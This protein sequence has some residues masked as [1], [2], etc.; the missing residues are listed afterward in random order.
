M[1]QNEILQKALAL[2]GELTE[3]RRDFHRHPELSYAEARTAAK[4]ADYLAAL[5]L[6]VERAIAG[7][8][9]VVGTL[10]SGKP[11]P[12]LLIR[13]D[14]DALPIEEQTAVPFASQNPG[15]MHACGHD[16]HTACAMVTAKLL[17]AL[18]LPRGRVKI[19]L[20]PAE[21]TPPGGAKTLVEEGGILDGV[22]AALA[23]HVYPQLPVG[24][25]GFLPGQMLANT[26]RFEIKVRG[27]GGHAA[28]P[29]LT[30]DAVA[31]AV[32]VYQ[33]LQYLVSRETDPLSPV[34]LTVGSIHGGTASNVIAG[35]VKMVGTVRTL[36]DALARQFPEKMERVVA[37]VCAATKA[38]YDFDYQPGYPSLA[39][40][41]AFTGAAMQSARAELG[42]EA[43]HAIERPL[44][45]GEDFAYIAQRVPSVFFW[46][47]VGN[48]ARGITHS[49]H[50][51]LFD[52]DE[53]ALPLGVAALAAIALDFLRE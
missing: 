29:H 16:A 24:Q 2:K 22:H 46:L 8:H 40:D 3:I 32:Q 10:D 6:E 11:G 36:D 1:G 27:Q 14:M 45:G 21:E 4:G 43:V 12:T 35:E 41:P 42:P 37:G 48:A 53:D 34:V 9:G 28:M 38:A 33:S 17:T 49:V 39:N 31:V 50:S 23:L 52:L 13:G 7:T 51:A 15:A 5:G 25:V 20:Q 19:L 30:V 18:A 44:M 47:G 26:G